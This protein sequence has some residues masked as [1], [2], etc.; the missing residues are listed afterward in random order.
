VPGDATATANNITASE[1][2]FRISIFSD[3]IMLT[4]D[5]LVAL[6]LYVLLKAVNNSIALLAAF[7]RLVHAAVYGINLLNL[8]FVLQISKNTDYMSVFAPEQLHALMLFFI[9]A[10]SY[11][12]VIGLVFFGFHCLILGYLIIKSGFLPRILGFL[13]IFAA[14][15]YQTDNFA[16][17]LLTNYAQY[18]TLFMMVVFIPAFI[19]ELSLALWLLFKGVK[20]QESVYQQ[21]I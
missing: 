19:A 9:N 1:S 4:F 2:L 3:F 14:L 10:H 6:T 5:V 13:M 21:T 17:V 7:F 8:F 11:G 18:E 15:G 16:H 20:E 12:Y